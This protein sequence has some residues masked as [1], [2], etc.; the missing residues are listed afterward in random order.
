MRGCWPAA[1]GLD[2]RRVEPA[3]RL[4][5]TRGI[6]KRHYGLEL[7]FY[8]DLN[9]LFSSAPSIAVTARRRGSSADWRDVR[10]LA[11]WTGRTIRSIA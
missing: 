9:R 10:R 6:V 2:T 8:D 4:R 3:D 7:N 11:E 5:T 1:G